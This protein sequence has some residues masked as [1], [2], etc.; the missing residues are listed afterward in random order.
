MAFLLEFASANN[1]LNAA[2]ALIDQAGPAAQPVRVGL[3]LGDV[4]ATEGG[5]LLGHTVNIAARLQ[6]EAGRNCIIVSRAV[7]DLVRGANAARLKPIGFIDID[8]T[9]DLVEAF[10]FDPGGRA[11]A[12]AGRRRRR[13]K[14]AGV[15]V[16]VAAAA[17]VVAI[18]SAAVS[19]AGRTAMLRQ[20]S[21]ELTRELSASG[22]LSQE[23]IDGAFWRFPISPVPTLR[24]NDP[25]SRCCGRGKPRARS[26]HLNPSPPI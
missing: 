18:W 2:L 23:S 8:K 4:M 1:A 10:A 11:G 16:G 26:A 12:S 15:A 5:D 25:R 13:W 17:L 24:L 14:I 3:H 21:A 20:L 19:G 22:A 6:T 9:S 7:F